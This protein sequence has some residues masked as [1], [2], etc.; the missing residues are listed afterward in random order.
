MKYVIWYGRIWTPSQGW[1][2]YCHSSASTCGNPSTD[3]TL[4]HYDH[5]HISVIH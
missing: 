5:V 1:H 3:T 2:A 4:N